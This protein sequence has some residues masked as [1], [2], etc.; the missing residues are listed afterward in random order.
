MISS[1]FGQVHGL[2]LI[3]S[4]LNQSYSQLDPT[5]PTPRCRTSHTT[6]ATAVDK[7]RVA[8]APASAACRTPRTSVCSA[9]HPPRRGAL[10][11]LGLAP[12]AKPV[13][14]ET[15]STRDQGLPVYATGSPRSPPSSTSKPESLGPSI[16]K[17]GEPDPAQRSAAGP[18]H[19]YHFAHITQ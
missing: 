19:L 7:R 6:T 11:A 8:P 14:L 4:K 10:L 12:Q 17:V 13:S 5:N 1:F 2:G 15:T 16:I 18:H 3:H 9:W